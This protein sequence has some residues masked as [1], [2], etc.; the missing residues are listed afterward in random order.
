MTS[1]TTQPSVDLYAVL[2]VSPQAT[3]ADIRTA[4]RKAA[5]HSHPDKGGSEEAFLN[6]SLAFEVLSSESSRAKYDRRRHQSEKQPAPAGGAQDRSRSRKR[7]RPGSEDTGTGKSKA[8]KRRAPLSLDKL[9]AELQQMLQGLPPEERREVIESF[10]KPV[11]ACLLKFMA[12]RAE[13]R[14]AP[15]ESEE[16]N[17]EAHDQAAQGQESGSDE[18]QGVTSVQRF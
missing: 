14:R 8:G 2:D 18:A 5:L 13:A 10:T 9:L 6:V 11:R 12:S 7:Q 16:T 1:A 4:Y 17:N 15:A 3:F